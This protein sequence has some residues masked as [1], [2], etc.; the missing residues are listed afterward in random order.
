MELAGIA[1]DD[2]GYGFLVNFSEYCNAGFVTSWGQAGIIITALPT[3]GKGA[4]IAFKGTLYFIR[5]EDGLG[6]PLTG[7]WPIEINRLKPIR[8]DEILDPP[9]AIILGQIVDHQA[10]FS[11]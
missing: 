10:L 3:I 5:F 11:L 6:Q 4:L 1:P 9:F 7:N 2:D 8:P